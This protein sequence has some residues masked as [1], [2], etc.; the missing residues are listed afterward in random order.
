MT[1]RIKPIS[2][3]ELE[4]YLAIPDLTLDP[5]DG[6]RPHAILLVYE[7]ME[8]AVRELWPQTEVRVIRNNPIVTSL[9]C[10]D[11]LLV[12][13]DNISRSSTYTQY[14][15]TEHCLQSHTS[16][17]IPG[18]LKELAAS[19]DEWEDVTVIV[20]GLAYRRDIKDKTHLGVLHQV[21]IWRIV[22]NKARGKLG[23]SDLLELVTKIVQTT[24]PDWEL[25]IV[26]NPHP[27]TN[28]GIEVNVTHPDGRDIEIL[29][30]GLLGRD[31]ITLSGMD[32]DKVSG[33][34][35][36]SGLD[37][38]TMTLK[39]I[40]DIRYLRSTNPKIAEQMYDLEDYKVVS[41]QPAI[42][43]DLSYSVP[44]N[45]VEED[46]SQEIEAAI[47][48]EIDSLESVELL[49]ETDYSTLNDIAKEKLGIRSDQKN[50]L[51]RITLRDLNKTLTK[52]EANQIYK[53]IYQKVNYGKGGYLV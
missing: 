42:Q 46:I 12:P 30:C 44:I 21:D 38:L 16:A 40:P 15:D 22:K 33:L 4:K 17:Q 20:P 9:D 37:R 1:I 27:Y 13:K 31:I 26:N 52:D 23:K 25:R 47:R 2:S 32:P 6:E 19:Y 34:A 7:K 53:D 45:Y 35:S 36:G 3:D 43:R 48:G 39:D 8:R 24:C 50:I 49:S 14:V 41:L 29:E 28:E 11:N 10:Y 51:V 18:A 5:A